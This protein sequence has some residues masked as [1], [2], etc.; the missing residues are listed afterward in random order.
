MSGAGVIR[1]KGSVPGRLNS[2]C[3][4]ITAPQNRKVPD[5]IH[6]RI[7]RRH[8][9]QIR[10]RFLTANVNKR[11]NDLALISSPSIV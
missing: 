4:T 11:V 1:L 6:H 7:V 9:E 3:T 5:F 2:S 10:I 8:S